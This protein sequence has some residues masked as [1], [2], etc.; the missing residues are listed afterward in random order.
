[1]STIG[2]NIEPGNIRSS[3]I[4]GLLQ[5]APTTCVD[6]LGCPRATSRSRAEPATSR[7][8]EALDRLSC[9]LRDQFEVLVEVEHC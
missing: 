5:R 7:N 6:S 1:M 3:S 8:V 2:G 9:D 4:W